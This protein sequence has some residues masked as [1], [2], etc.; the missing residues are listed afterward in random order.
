MSCARCQDI[1]E[2]PDLPHVIRTC[3]GCGRELRIHEPGEHGRGFRVAEGDQVVIP[4][5]WLRLS[6]NPLK[7][8]GQFSRQGIVWFAEH[9]HLEELPGKKEGMPAEIERLMERNEDVLR[10]SDL[11]EGLDMANEADADQIV[12]ILEENKDR[13]E[14]WA[15]LSLVFLTLVED[16]TSKGD[17]AQAIWAMGCAE[18]CRSML[19]FKE[20]L[21][22]VV[23]MGQSA[24][25]V[26]D[27]LRTWDANQANNDERFWQLTFAENVYAI[28]QVFAA[29][30]VFIQD[31]AY[32]GGM[33]VDRTSARIADFLFAHES[34]GEAVLVEIKT[35]AT[36]L[37]GRKYRG[38]YRPS[39]EL[40]GAVMQVLDYRRTLVRDQRSIMDK[41]GREL[42]AFSPDCVVII[43]TGASELD[44]EQKRTAFEDFR[45]NSRDVE[46][47]T[48][49]ELFGK[50]EVLAGL[51]SLARSE[52]PKDTDK[53]V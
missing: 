4:D 1:V 16:A 28:S 39:P 53:A 38:T 52:P 29:P 26:I 2:R 17:L 33:S 32:V 12:R 40:S 22:E 11:L 35:P 31:S 48:Y 14:W 24:R 10:R 41:A 36:R 25:R 45:A 3:E 21:E 19:I 49:D 46:I 13:S 37:L 30:L 5:G 20:H 51:F 43:G 9:I 7:G 18:R 23:F 6:F 47:V 15:Y 27:I 50:I 8:S 42:H 34:S 44:T